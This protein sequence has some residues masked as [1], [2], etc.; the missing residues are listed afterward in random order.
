MSRQKVAPDSQEPRNV[1]LF[2]GAID[3]LIIE[4]ILQKMVR[5]QNVVPDKA[6][7][8]QQMQ[9]LSSRFPTR[10]EYQKALAAQG[11]T[12][13]QLRKNVE[14]SMGMQ[15]LLDDNTKNAPVATD[16]EVQKFYDDN[17][18]KFPVPEQAHAEH[19]LLLADA[20]STPEQKAE[21]KKKLE[22]IRADIEANK[23]TFAD[24]AK[25]YS[26][27]PG[28][29][30]QGGDLGFFPRGRMVKPFED[31]AFG[32]QPGALSQIVETQYG[33]HLIRTIEIK[34]AGKASLAE[35]KPTIKQF[36][37]QRNKIAAVQQYTKDLKAKATVETFMTPDEFLKRHP[38]IK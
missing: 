36:L 4:S 18:D 25:Q 27:D 10:E 17:S 14:R 31:A 12:E 32:G 38:E 33:Y 34:P 2:K 9:M 5:E 30:P 7:V 1:T 24:A 28:S 23:I 6:M 22:G 35:A 26:Q 21:I 37:D 19:I 8:D 13:D 3:N 16:A 15:K 20:K 11:L 29:A